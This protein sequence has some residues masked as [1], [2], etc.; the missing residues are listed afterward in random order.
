MKL[1]DEADLTIPECHSR[2]VVHP[3]NGMF[4]HVDFTRVHR[5]EP[6]EHVKERAL[7]DT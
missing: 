7:P 2:L 3:V 5:I 4:A 1:K 6:S